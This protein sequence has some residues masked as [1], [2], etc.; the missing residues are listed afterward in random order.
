VKEKKLTRRDFLRM[1]VLSA[2][3][4]ALAACAPK[5]EVVKETVVVEKQVEKVVTATPLPPEPVTI[6]FTSNEDLAI[7][8]PIIFDLIKEKGLNINLE[9]DRTVEPGGWAAYCDNVIT[10]IAGGDVLDLIHMA[11]NGMFTLVGKNVIRPLDDFLDADTAFKQ[12]VKTDI[13]EGLLKMLQW[14]GKQYAFPGDWN[15]VIFHYNYKIF[16]E[17]GVPEPKFDWTWDDFLEAS[18]AIADVQGT[19]DD[20]YAYSWYNWTGG[21]DPWFFNNDTSVVTDDWLDSN[22]LDP[23]VAETL[24]FMADLILKHKVAPVPGAWDEYGQFMA[25]HQGMRSCGG[26]CIGMYTSNDWY[27]F[28]FAYPPSNRGGPIKTD[29]GTAGETM[30]TMSQHP[31][32]AWEVLKLLNGPE[33]QTSFLELY[34]SLQSRRS[35]VD[36]DTFRNLPGDSPAD[37]SIFFESLD[38]AKRVVT[39]PN[40]TIIEP[41]LARWWEQIW[42][43][44]LSVEEAVQG[45]HVELQAEMDRMKEEMNL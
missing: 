24:Q 26:W 3:G 39:P 17:K 33:I 1:S 12:D 14:Q 23:K 9:I 18:L 16:E 6:K 41:L 44:E 10:R 31:E 32:E 19:A 35:V 21:M 7:Y 8:D 22:M 30:T 29:V 38:Y 20:M 27:D 13:H 11:V 25:G 5:V 37:M 43:G 28:K 40:F 34:G 4:A 2:T 45:C 15:N 36:T 42:A